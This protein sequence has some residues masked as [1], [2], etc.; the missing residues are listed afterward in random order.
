MVQFSNKVSVDLMSSKRQFSKR[1]S[2]NLTL[3][4]S[5]PTNLYDTMH[6]NTVRLTS[7]RVTSAQSLHNILYSEF[8]LVWS[9]GVE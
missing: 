1:D 4:I 5:M 2:I 6:R 7:K 3:F 9:E 8:L